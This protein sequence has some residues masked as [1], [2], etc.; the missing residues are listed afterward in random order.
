[1]YFSVFSHLFSNAEEKLL[2]G[3]T[4]LGWKNFFKIVDKWVKFRYFE[5]KIFCF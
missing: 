2:E 4:R 1:M 3:I 5:K